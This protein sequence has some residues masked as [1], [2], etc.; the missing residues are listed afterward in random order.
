[1]RGEDELHTRECPRN[2]LDHLHLP[3]RV[4]EQVDFVD[5]DDAAN[6]ADLASGG[7]PRVRWYKKSVTQPMNPRYPSDML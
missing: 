3:K 2:L 4:Q 6:I 1:M 7:M 5:Q